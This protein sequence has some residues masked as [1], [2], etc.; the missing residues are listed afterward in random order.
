M[1]DNKRDSKQMST[2]ESLKKGQGYNN[3]RGEIDDKKNTPKHNG[4]NLD[5]DPAHQAEKEKNKQR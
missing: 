5:N 1:D 2:E 4:Q 3:A